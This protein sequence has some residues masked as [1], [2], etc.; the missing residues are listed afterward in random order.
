MLTQKTAHL[1]GGLQSIDY[2]RPPSGDI[3]A[4]RLAVL[5]SRI[6]FGLHKKPYLLSV[7]PTNSMIVPKLPLQRLFALLLG[8]YPLQLAAQI[9]SLPDITETGRDILEDFIQNQDTE[10]DFDFNAY[11]EFLEAY[12]QNPLD[13]NRASEEELRELLLLTDVQILNLLN[14]RRSAGD[15]VSIYELQAIPG[16]DLPSINRILPYVGINVALDDFQISR[17]EMLSRGKNEFFVRYN[18]FL[19]EQRGFS[20]PEDSTD[21]RYEGDPGRLYF[22]YQH[23]YSNKL[24]YGITAEKDRGE[25]FFSGSNQQG[26]DFYSA[27]FFLRDYRSWLPAVAVGDFGISFGQ[28]LILFSGFNGGK[29]TLVSSVKRSE[30]TIRPYA[31]V[32]EAIFMRGLGVT[33]K[34]AAHWELTTFASR[35]NRDGNLQQPDTLL[36]DLFTQSISSFDLDGL[37]RT[38]AEIEDENALQQTSIGG[39]VTYEK[40]TVKLGFNV[41]Y[42]QFDKALLFRERPY[43]RFNFSGDRLLNASV[44]YS[45]VY[46]NFNLF[47]ETAISDNGAV[48]TLN[49]LLLALDR[50]AELAILYRNYPRDYQALN[51]NPFAETTGGRNEEG[52]YFGLVLRPLKRVTLSSYFDFWRHPWLRFNVDAPS[53]GYEYR[54]RLSYEIRRKLNVYIEAL[55]EVKEINAPDNESNFNFL[56]PQ[57]RFR[58]RLHIGHK[59]TKALELRSRLDW[60]FYDNTIDERSQGFVLLQ[61]ILFRPIEFP[62]SFTTRFAIFDTDGFQVRFYH[63]ENNLLNTFS[64]PPYY[65]RGTRFYLNLRYRPVKQFTFEVRFARTYWNNQDSFGSGLETIEGNTRSEFAAQIKYQFSR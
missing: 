39:N 17:G 54:T 1:D 34:P 62:L 27:H 51:A 64:I 40:G 41:L 10:D 53:R 23:A 20:D 45:W 25:A 59:V 26:F 12:R 5:G 58:M 8:L 57:Q 3:A 7:T 4:C 42:D 38:P 49:G 21:T 14:Y 31:S 60:G 32:N 18:Q 33:I 16:F 46:R 56:V 43:N 29:G 19:E 55:N 6:R 65:N 50:S 24:R 37:H 52:L 13:L 36:G 47:G 30:R 44:D 15:L 28:G 2:Q 22:R 35:R 9:D 63:Y 61:D 48:A 11:F